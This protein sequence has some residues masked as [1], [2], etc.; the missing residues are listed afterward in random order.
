[1][2]FMNFIT[3]PAG[4]LKLKVDAAQAPAAEHSIT[5]LFGGFSTVCVVM[6]Q[7]D[8]QATE[9]VHGSLHVS[10]VR[11]PAPFGP[12]VGIIAIIGGMVC[13]GIID[14]PDGGAGT[15]GC[16]GLA[17]NACINLLDESASDIDPKI[18]IIDTTDF[19]MVV[20]V[21]GVHEI[22]R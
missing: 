15:A 4:Q 18:A 10:L 13:S 22:G 16:A 19:N 3:P 11:G 7:V 2:L 17:G 9:V 5:K 20:M 14:P 1:M 21:G 6:A 8:G 12:E